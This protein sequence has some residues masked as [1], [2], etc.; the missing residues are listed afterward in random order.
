M[1]PE[2]LVFY[3]QL[4]KALY[5]LL[6]TKTLIQRNF[7]NSSVKSFRIIW[8]CGRLSRSSLSTPW[9]SSNIFFYM[10]VLCKIHLEEI[11]NILTIQ[12]HLWFPSWTH[13]TETDKSKYTFCPDASLDGDIRSVFFYFYL[14]LLHH[15]SCTGERVCVHVCSKSHVTVRPRQAAPK[16][17][18]TIGKNDWRAGL[19]W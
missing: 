6:S 11:R 2:T 15:I 3:F 13:S 8:K 14:R 5:F 9:T 10:I 12:I 4:S 1:T 16:C 18:Q 7:L 19:F 17:E